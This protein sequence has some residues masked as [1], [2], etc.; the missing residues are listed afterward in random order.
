[1]EWTVRR[2]TQEDIKYLAENLREA[3]VREIYASSG[4]T[5]EAS[6]SDALTQPSLGTWVGIY[7]GNPELIFGCADY[8]HNPD[9]GVPWMVCT[10]KLTESPREFMVK[11]KRW[12]KGWLGHYGHLM[13][14]VY[15]ENELHLRWLKWCGFSFGDIVADYGHTKEPFQYFEMK[16]TQRSKE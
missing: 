4:K 1:M 6:L 13:N 15:C 16:I 2:A 9:V 7:A 14:F 3:D 5:P 12:V 8:K 10:D 11:S